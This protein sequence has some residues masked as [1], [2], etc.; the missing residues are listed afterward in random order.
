V[1]NRID[2]NLFQDVPP[3]GG[4]GRETIQVGQSQP[5]WGLTE[6]RTVVEHNTFLRC[7]GEAEVISNKSSH[8][9]YRRNL[10]REC[11]GE[12]V[13]RGG[14]HCVLEGNRFERCSGG[15][16]LSGTHHRV[17]DNVI[18]GNRSTGI[19]LLYGMTREL[20][21]HYQASTGCLV[22]NNTIV[23][24]GEVGIHIGAGGGRDWGERGIANVAPYGNRFINNIVVGSTETFLLSEDCPDNVVE[25]NLYY[26]IC[27]AAVFD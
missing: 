6:P 16:R 12:L 3:I 8:N 20:G 27:K 2:H 17:V 4:N 21:G 19:R 23:D 10:F 13:M 11:E 15:I 1:G 25:H 14:S 22:A 5:K 7:D 24:A 26:T 18:V 9:I